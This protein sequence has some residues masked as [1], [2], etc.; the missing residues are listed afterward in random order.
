MAAFTRLTVERPLAVNSAVWLI[1]RPRSKL[2]TISECFTRKSS[3]LTVVPLGRPN[4]PLSRWVISM[5]RLDAARRFSS[6]FHRPVTI[7]RSA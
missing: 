7:N 5:P 3:V 4:L 6:Y 1:E 2:V